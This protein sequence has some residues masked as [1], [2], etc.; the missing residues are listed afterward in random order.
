MVR[1][2][3]REWKERGGAGG[4]QDK[5]HRKEE[6]RKADLRAGATRGRVP[7]ECPGPPNRDSRESSRA[8]GLTFEEVVVL[9]VAGAH[10]AAEKRRG[11]SSSGTGGTRGRRCR[12]NPNAELQLPDPVKNPSLPLRH[13]RQAPTHRGKYFRGR[14]PAPQPNKGGVREF[15]VCCPS[16]PDS[17]GFR[18]A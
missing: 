8:H 15:G 18:V 6:L 3:I 2:P 14:R 1:T 12:G 5:P 16:F 11:G 13:F 10:C 17:E 9:V 4:P 7:R